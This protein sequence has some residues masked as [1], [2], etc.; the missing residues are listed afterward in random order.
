MFQTYE[1]TRESDSMNSGTSSTIIK[2]A[3]SAVALGLIVLHILLPALKVDSIVLGLIAIAVLPWVYTF[4]ESAKLPG[5][6]EIKFREIQAAGEK[7]GGSLDIVASAEE[8]SGDDADSLARVHLIDPN[9]ALVAVRIEI[10]K[11]IRAIAAAH[12]VSTVAPV[13]T[14]LRELSSRG[15]IPQQTAA[16]AELLVKYG[17]QA[18]HGATVDPLVSGWAISS[19][20][21]IIRALDGLAGSGGV[22]S[23]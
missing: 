20:P 12:G 23:A 6:W 3:V 4:V 19:G 22:S 17:N 15:F 18:A 13:T 10:E 9:L 7:I 14:L 2:T 1:T 21:N 16:G 8:N 5:G 11:S